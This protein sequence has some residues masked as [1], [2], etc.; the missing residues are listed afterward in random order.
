VIEADDP[1]RAMIAPIG[2]ADPVEAKQ[3]RWR[4][5]SSRTPF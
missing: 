3:W 1:I 5:K 2:S 4:S